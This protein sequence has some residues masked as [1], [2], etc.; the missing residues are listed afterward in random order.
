MM[1][2]AITSPT[3]VFAW[4]A[5]EVLNSN[6]ADLRFDSSLCVKAGSNGT[7]ISACASNT[8]GS[9]DLDVRYSR[10]MDNGASWSAP[11]Q[12]NTKSPGSIAMEDSPTIAGGASGR[13][14]AAWASEDP[15]NMTLGD[16]KDILCAISTDDGATW[17]GAAR[18]NYGAETDSRFDYNPA[19]DTDGGNTWVAAWE[20][21]EFAPLA[22]ARTG[23][24]RLARSS[25]GGSNWSP[26]VTLDNYP[27]SD[28]RTDGNARLSTDR[29]GNWIV[30]WQSINP[31]NSPSPDVNG[32]D[33]DVW[34]SRSTDNGL[35]WSV[36][37]PLQVNA[38]SDL[39]ADLSPDVATDGAGNWICVFS[40]T[41]TLGESIG[42]D[43]DV[44]F[45]R[46]T[47]NGSTWSLPVALNSNA[48]SDAGNDSSPRITFAGGRF[49]AA[50]NT[51]SRLGGSHPV[52][53][54]IM[55]ADSTDGGAT[56]SAPIL[57]NSNATTDNAHDVMPQVTGTTSGQLVTAWRTL[58]PD[59]TDGDMLYSRQSPASA[60][61]DWALY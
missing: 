14:I 24:I 9:V 31:P 35:N 27:G 52:D 40:S 7:L 18:L 12:L 34:Y 33:W 6:S 51:T 49:V 45:C 8:T 29:N 47:D 28:L 50:W 4:S 46:S 11:A 41:D 2:I 13:W 3:A 1:L 43:D 42:T 30:V 15:M 22:T 25:D 53:S 61:T 48:A 17:G 16:D 54:D 19:L 57:L 36:P 23:D 59:R 10:S 20:S 55:V 58:L 39:G 26:A 60:V 32:G 37:I 5:P 56:W 44:L 38:D 21:Y